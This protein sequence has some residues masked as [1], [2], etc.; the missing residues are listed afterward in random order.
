VTANGKLDRN[1]LPAPATASR[2]LPP[3]EG[4]SA[5]ED[6]IAGIWCEVL[7]VPRVGSE[8]NFFDL[9]GHSLLLTRVQVLLRD[10]LGR[11]VSLMDLL[12]HTSVRALARHLEPGLAV[13]EKPVPRATASHGPIAIVGLTG[14]F[15]GASGVE[16]LWDNLRAGVASIARF[17]DEDLA[18]S[19]I[20][21]AL[22]RDPR[23]VPAAGVL[24]GV[25]L[26][27]AGFFGYNPRE[28]ELLDPQQRLFL[29][30]A[31]EAL[32]HAGYDSQ[33]VPG[34][35]GVFA[36]LG[37]NR[38]LHQLLSSVDPAAVGGPQL[39]LGN[40]KDFLATRVSY[41]LD[42]QG[43]SM[44]VQ[45]ACSS[46]LLA[47]HLACQN[48]RLGACDMAL[49]G[50][51]TIAVPQRAGY[52]YE[53]GGIVSP[54][55]YC[56]TF[57]ASARGTVGGSGVGIVVLKRLED[58]L[59]DGDTIH[60]VL[61]GSAANNDGGSN[62]A[63]YTAPSVT[64][65]SNAISAAL[66]DAGVS[67]ETI[68][69][70]EAHGSATPLGD[71]IEVAALTRAFRRE[72]ERT[73]FCSLGAVKT[74][75]G[76][77]D[78]AAGVTGLIKTVLALE[79]RQ[80]PPSL[81]FETP[82]PAID[83][84]ASP[85]RVADRLTD[86]TSSGEPRRAGVS[87]F[88]IG[89]TNVHAVLEEAPS[90]AL[91]GPSR[92]WQ[93]LLLS[94]RTPAALERMTDRLADRLEQDP[95]LDLADVAYTLRVGRRPFAHRRA[96]LAAT[97]EEAVT[98]LRERDPQRVWTSTESR[99]SVAFLLPGV[100]DQYP[101]LAR[102]LYQ[103]EPVFREELDRCAELLLPHLGLDLREV[104]FTAAEEAPDP[105]SLFGRGRPRK[106]VL[107]ETR[108]AQPAMFA[109]GY[110]LARLWMSWGVRPAALLGYSL[111]EYT[112]ACLAGVM[113]LP[114][115]LALVARRARLIGELPP[116]ALLAVPLSEEETR[117]RLTPELSLAAV[118]A[119]A[120]SVVS[121]PP[122][123]ISELER[124]LAE[125]GVPCRRLQADQA[126]HSWMLQPVAGELREML[127]S[128]PLATPRIPYL[129]NVT[130]TWISAA[131]ATDPD[132]WVR[133]LVSTVRFADGVAEL[134]REPG[135][136]LV[137]MGPQAL[138]S[139]ALQ[140]SPAEGAVFSSLRHEMDRQPDPRFLLQTLGRLWLS[141]AEID[142]SGF[143]G[144]ERR[145]RVPLPAYPFERQRYWIEPGLRTTA[146][147]MVMLPEGADPAWAAALEARGVR[148]VALPSGPPTPE[149][150]DELLGLAPRPTLQAA[151]VEPG[152][153]RPGIDTPY[154]EPRTDLERR[155]AAIWGD[156]LGIGQVGV[157]D[158][159]FALGGHSL[160]GLQLLSRVQA[161]LGV[162]ISLHT[163]F[164]A[165]TVA[166]LAV[167]VEQQGEAAFVPPLVPVPREGA[168]PLSFAQQRLWFI[169]Q[170]QPGTPLYNLPVVLRVEG[171]LDA[172]VLERCL[173]EIARR[174]EAVRTVF[175]LEGDAPVQVILPPAPFVLPRIDLSTLPELAREAE[176]LALA[177]EEAARPFDLA[178]GPLLR[179]V[180]LRLAPEDHA[181]ALT[182]HHVASDGWS[183]GLLVREVAALYAAFSEG[184]P[185]PL[186][187][188]PI[189]YAD[190]AVWQ[191]SWLHGE[192]L[193]RE[194]DWWRQQ[195]A[196][197]PPLLDLPTDRPRPAVQS[198]R[199]STRPVRWAAERV[200]PV[201][202]L[203]RR[204]GATLFMMLL[205]G[206]EALLGR[207]SGQDDLA[208]GTPIA[209]RNRVEV[210]GLIGFFVNNLVLRGSL[211]GDPTFRELLA[212]VRETELAAQAHQD[213]PFEK[214]VEELATE[215]S[216][217]YAPLV[218]VMFALQNTPG[219]SVEVSDLRMQAVNPEITVA[220]FD[221][222]L[223]L[224]EHGGGLIGTIEY[225]TDLFDATTIDR[226]IAGLERLLA[227]AVM[228]PDLRVAELPLLSAGE[229]HQVL[230]EWNDTGGEGWE[231]PVTF[232]VERWCREQPDAPAVVDAAGNVLTWG[233]LGERSGRLAGFLRSRGVG[234]ESI[235][236][237]Q[238]ERS[239]DLL[240]AQLGVLKVGAA[241]LSLDPA[242]PAERLAF[243]LE[244]TAASV[245]LTQG[246]LEEIA[247][248][249]PL[250]PQPVEPDQ[251]AYVLYTSGS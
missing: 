212:Q 81:H 228:N 159:F 33:R 143:L 87:A 180:L 72:T 101:G 156:L 174:H 189:Q 245:V 111:G 181:V 171:P 250:P 246:S 240:V 223:N 188:L 83:F 168:L 204:Y 158:N 222:T 102:G 198:V 139:L 206:F 231:E 94:A 28:A 133:H 221:L 105:R 140:Q 235:V 251:L 141:G 224:T 39:L 199:G 110:A 163:L 75:V 109:V 10:R 184:K 52:L 162:E 126:F 237:V 193:E 123:A 249:E 15:P 157:H 61:L 95:D 147:K 103:D 36:S 73:G 51:V 11:E 42:L 70:V 77:L 1:A 67:P 69:Y 236:A 213:V 44:T 49:A 97:R 6:A 202:A 20:P 209:G 130:G 129:S 65:Q 107:Q 16:A 114:D 146:S 71:P 17:S 175:A 148:V 229:R 3:E 98:A 176:A 216:L 40:D 100:G 14:R 122:E 112:A 96:V 113:E 185:S 153:V 243:M 195:L 179:T 85:F 194:I 60:A 84:A 137:E 169:D 167:E 76:H 225:G 205:A 208:V 23:Y 197:L 53:E 58:A 187:P 152:H 164:E 57:D 226:L 128:I 196:G 38:Y 59:A 135:R 121:G 239:A 8:E 233:E 220:K 89:G 154:E 166:S 149:A 64:G 118:N 144:D 120:V 31:W 26:F 18:A 22:R 238:M 74:N 92:P 37:F 178:R 182:M 5:L 131:E 19:G 210:E 41:K 150:L 2:D 217:A 7:G 201:E 35:V 207:W 186:L 13:V 218:Q 172:A 30:C 211:A 192:A 91:S 21:P 80:I 46:S 173:E 79:H 32:E 142:W 232:L 82:N 136:V 170:L 241:Y 190:F 145:R 68:S 248:Y 99:R 242:H 104:L 155:L 138:G 45:T 115:A 124:R 12:T 160:L 56:R 161:G 134:W 191:R 27:D 203:G 86:W 63:G 215:R 219:G 106:T 247:R 183:M 116:G 227:A 88:G 43:P 50:G 90:V 24:E 230:A 55:G 117:A 108:I 151:P 119:P 34:P 125:E 244:E 200:Q 234:A 78:A 29:E 127:R 54:D 9:G 62:K 132:Y 25:E 93:V 214:L 66:A 177:E 165:P 47:V 48:L 4:R